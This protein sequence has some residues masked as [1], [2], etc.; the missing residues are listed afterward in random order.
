M[1]IAIYYIHI[2]HILYTYRYIHT[3]VMLGIISTLTSGWVLPCSGPASEARRFQLLVLSLA[4]HLQP[5]WDAQYRAAWRRGI[6]DHHNMMGYFER[7]VGPQSNK[8]PIKLG[9]VA[10]W[11]LPIQNRV[12]RKMHDASSFSDD[13]FGCPTASPLKKMDSS[14]NRVLYTLRLHF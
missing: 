2:P 7:K 4:G 1:Y 14:K 11:P 13:G 8:H 6:F 9:Q 5:V 3:H 12:L 10:T